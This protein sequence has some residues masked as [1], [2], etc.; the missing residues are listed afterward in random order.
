MDGNSLG[1]TYDVQGTF[2]NQQITDLGNG[3]GSDM[4]SKIVET[5]PEA[6]IYPDNKKNSGI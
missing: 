2:D 5:W 4:L 1:Y 6:V 3:S